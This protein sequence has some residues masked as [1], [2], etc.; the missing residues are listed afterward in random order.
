MSEQNATESQALKT[1]T[2]QAYLDYSM[3]V[4]LDRALPKLADGLKPVQR[5]IVYA[6]SQLGLKDNAKYKK[7]AR[8]IGDVLGKFHPHGDTAC[9]EAMVLMAQPFSYRYPLVDGQGNWGSQDDPK[10]FAAMRYTE[11]KLSPYAQVL[12]SEIGQGTTQWGPNFDGTMQEPLILPARLPNLL[13]NGGSGI[14]VGMATDVPPH[15]LSEVVDG[16]V[17]LLAHPK[18]TIEE[19]MEHIPAPDYPSGGEIISSKA[20]LLDMYKT[21]KGAVKMRATY[22]IDGEWVHI[23]A[24]PYQASP[25]KICMQIAEQ[26]QAKKLA[27][28]V[29][30]QDLSDHDNPVHLALQLRSNRVDV[31]ALMGHLFATTDLEKNGRVN[32]NVIGLNQKPKVMGLLAICQEW[33]T[34]RKDTVRRRLQHRLE[35]INARLHVLEGFLIAFLNIDEVIAI[36]RTEDHPKA[37]LMERFKLSDAQTEAILELKLRQLA[38]LA[39]IAIEEEAAK[40]REEK[41]ALEHLLSDERA[42]KK[43]I[44]TELLS[45]KKT[46]GDARRCALVERQQ[47]QAMDMQQQSV[48]PI[49]VILSKHLW[50]RVAKGQDIDPSQMNFKAGDRLLAS[51]K[52][53]SNQA[54]VFMAQDGRMFQVK[55]HLLPSARSQ[56][57]PLTK[58][59]QLEGGVGIVG[60]QLLVPESR[61]LIAQDSGYGFVCTGADV[62]SKNKAGKQVL[63]LTPKAEPLLPVKI[64]SDDTHVAVSTSSGRFWVFPLEQMP[65][66]KRGK[67]NRMIHIKDDEIMLNMQTFAWGQGDLWLWAG[68]R[69]LVLAPRDLE[70]YMGDRAKRGR[71]LPRGF[72]RIS[73]LEWVA[74]DA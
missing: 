32:F 71:L 54:L 72:Q 52:G 68:K 40:L 34:F 64:D 69:K 38:K 49:T 59:V 27:M 33:L 12:L 11:A 55:P 5:R 17:H 35:Q 1:F 3:Y 42:F 62:L 44:R 63:S 7:S 18:A 65:E 6:M 16:L 29:D 13:L 37:V 39:R 50:V 56:G 66:M 53:K 31:E 4:I 73:A 14:A 47:A 36:I 26:M 10:S 61:W 45:D 41:E 28:V 9:Y 46:F 19:L 25:A 57:E 2:E 21:G 24:L 15:N 8:T 70:L 20:Q 22:E 67:G 74:K 43:L 51:A 30:I 60:M 23:K 48:E 58:F